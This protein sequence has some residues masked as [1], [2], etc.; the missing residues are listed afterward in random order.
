MTLQVKKRVHYFIYFAAGKN[1]RKV[2]QYKLTFFLQGYSP[3][4]LSKYGILH[5]KAGLLGISNE[6]L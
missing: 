3:S 6:E 5:V 4:L 2:V 1:V